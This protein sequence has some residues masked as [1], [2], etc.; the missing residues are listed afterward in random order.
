MRKNLYF[1]LSFQ[2]YDGH[3]FRVQPA[4]PESS[5]GPDMAGWKRLGRPRPG[6]GRGV[7]SE[8]ATR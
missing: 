4:D 3:L 5:G 8:T 1:E 7:H 6:A 2:N